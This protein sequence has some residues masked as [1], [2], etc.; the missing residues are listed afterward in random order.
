M[1]LAVIVLSA[2]APSISTTKVEMPT[3]KRGPL[4]V[5]VK[6]SAN[7][8]SVEITK[9]RQLFKRSF[10]NAG[11]HPVEIEGS[12]TGSR[13]ELEIV[14]SKY[15]HSTPAS[16]T[17]IF[18]GVGCVYL[19]PLFAPCLLLPGYYKPQFEI[20]ADVSGFQGGRRIFNESFTERS[21]SSA[22]LVDTGDDA[23]RHQLE[24]LA[25]HNFTASIV[26]QMDRQ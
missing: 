10:G 24:D 7:I 5:V 25:V 2:C 20:S 23:F 17:G 19:C 1:V 14:L 8:E 18:A 3:S 6:S 15:E 22:N 26:R 16:N 4:D 13:R 11:F 9:A 12:R 21:A